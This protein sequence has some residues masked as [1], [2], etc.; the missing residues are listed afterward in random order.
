LPSLR[1]LLFNSALVKRVCVFC[2]ANV[3]ADPVFARAA[4]QVG[5]VLAK[6]GL[7]L[8]YGGGNIGLMGVLA[9]AALAAGAEV[10]G[11]IPQAL[12]D[13]EL[14]HR[15]ITDLRIVQSM[16]ERKAMMADLSDGFIALPGGYGTLEEFCEI[17]TWGQLGLHRKPFGLLNIQH[18]YDPFVAQIDHAVQMKFIHP[19]NRDLLIVDDTID[20]LLTRFDHFKPPP[21]RQ[22]IDREE[23]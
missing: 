14:A 5:L 17:L 22:W 2:G 20:T 13:R 19:Q 9:D 3:G 7:G 4:Q 15:E 16:H 23:T 21:L 12:V 18:F 1:F 11:V 10:I 8:V 6:R